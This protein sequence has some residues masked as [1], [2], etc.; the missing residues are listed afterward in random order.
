MR[1]DIEGALNRAKVANWSM[2][3]TKFEI[4]HFVGDPQFCRRHIWIDPQQFVERR[5]PVPRPAPVGYEKVISQ[6]LT[7]KVDGGNAQAG[8]KHF[9]GNEEIVTLVL[10][11]LRDVA[12][13]SLKNVL[14]SFFGIVANED[15]CAC[16]RGSDV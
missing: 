8:A 1:Q 16:A 10:A 15:L 14:P 13:L 12:D 2:S 5:L 7:P 6:R 3:G 9:S 4:P 11:G